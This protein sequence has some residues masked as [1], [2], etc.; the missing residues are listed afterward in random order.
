MNCGGTIR[1]NLKA[2]DEIWM[3]RCLELA[4][5]GL[6]C[7][8][9]NPMV[10]AVLVRDGEVVGEGFHRE[11]GG[12]HAEVEAIQTAGKGVDLST[13]TLYVSLEPCCHQGKTPPCTD[14]I[15]SKKIKKVVVGTTDPNPLVAG[16]GLEQLR[17]SGIDVISG[18]LENECRELNR[19]YF[20]F[21][22][23]QRPYVIL[24]WAR[25]A[26]GYI[27]RKR[28]MAEVGNQERITCNE[29][30]ITVHRWRSEEQAIMVGTTTALMDN[31]SL[32]VRHVKGRNPLRVVVDK[33]LRI[34]DHYRVFDKT[35]KTI[36]FTASS[37]HSEPNIDFVQV[38]F[39]EEVIPRILGELYK[40]NIQSIIVE[41]GRE[42]VNS[43]IQGNNWDEARVFTAPLKLGSG[44]KGPS[45]PVPPA[46]QHKSGLDHLHIYR[47]E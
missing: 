15:L 14:L 43:F 35:Q 18:V 13:C 26:D 44:V 8:A 27:D 7:V 19:R 23:K 38:D 46:G 2:V 30:N 4:A 10:G 17:R 28:S 47:S 6:G 22:N 9:P 12:P 29:S 40:L 32:S 16:Q 31:P 20:T 45:L 33:D 24:K 39:L 5:N 21:L 42:L 1:I 25:S 3:K 36:V 41:G 11:F 34:P 37:H